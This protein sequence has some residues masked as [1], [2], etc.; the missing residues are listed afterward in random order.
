[1][2]RR[3]ATNRIQSALDALGIDWHSPRYG[4]ARLAGDASTILIDDNN[5]FGPLITPL[6]A[7]GDMDLDARQPPAIMRADAWR[8]S[9]FWRNAARANLR[10]VRNRIEAVLGPPDED[11]AGTSVGCRWRDQAGSI[12]IECWPAGDRHDAQWDHRLT[13]ACAIEIVSGWRRPLSSEEIRMI[14]D[15][16]VI[17]RGTPRGVRTLTSTPPSDDDAGYVREP[18]PEARTLDAIIGFDQTS[19]TL[20]ACPGRLLVIPVERIRSIRHEAY[21]DGIT[22]G[23]SAI[24]ATLEG[25]RSLTIAEHDQTHGLELVSRGVS[26]MLRVDV[27][28]LEAKAS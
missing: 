11:L 27:E 7:N 4:R 18:G 22:S 1:M 6:R 28:R 15:M 3:H 13:S 24:V 9:A 20:I 16:A 17:G 26:R 12:Q 19:G 8:P 14:E 2:S 23:H 21:A 10:H 5:A 25:G